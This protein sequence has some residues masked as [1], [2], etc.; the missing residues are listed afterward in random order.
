MPATALPKRQ[1]AFRITAY[2]ITAPVFFYLVFLR[3]MFTLCFTQAPQYLHK[4]CYHPLS[5]SSRVT[6]QPSAWL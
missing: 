4:V 6:A 3:L 5:V 1:P 2:R